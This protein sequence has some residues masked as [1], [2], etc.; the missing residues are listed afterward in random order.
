MASAAPL[1]PSLGTWAR[2]EFLSPAREARAPGSSH[3]GVGPPLAI[4][5]DFMAG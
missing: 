3:P 1:P 2:V 4:W 5:G